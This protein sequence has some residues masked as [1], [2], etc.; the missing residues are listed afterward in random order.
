MDKNV[1]ELA[2]RLLNTGLDEMPDREKRVIQRIAKRLQVSRN[3]NR[4]YI[5]TRTLGQRVSDRVAEFGG[6]WTF[7]GLS[8]GFMLIWAA[9]NSSLIVA[10]PVD[11]FPYVF[12]NLILSMLAALQAPI[13]MM[14]QNRQAARDRLSAAADYEVN[15]KA[16]LEIMG[17][18]EKMDHMRVAQL[19]FLVE[20][21]QKQIDL[22]TRL[23]ERHGQA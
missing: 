7:I 11:P 4:E 23:L 12:L 5:D 1:A 18:H 19:E 10:R 15:L 16:E 20:T 2:Q 8:V 6:S 22:L 9:V 13:I 21:Q 14:S 3:I 17:L